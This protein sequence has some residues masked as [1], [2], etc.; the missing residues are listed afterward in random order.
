MFAFS[1]YIATIMKRKI[2]LNIEE[3]S[4][5]EISIN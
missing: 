3:W 4:I 2:Y 1:L 5:K